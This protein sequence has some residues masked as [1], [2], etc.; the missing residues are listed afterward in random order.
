MTTEIRII[1]PGS[2][3]FH[4]FE[5]AAANLYPA[6]ILP[7]QLMKGMNRDFLHTFYVAVKNNKVTGR[8]GLYHNPQLT[9]QHQ[10]A[11][12]A[13][14]YE[15]MNDTE[16]AN[17]LL[18]Q[19]VKDA[20]KL[21]A[22][23]LIGPMNGSTWDDYRFSTHHQHPNFLLEPYHQLYY[24]DQFV[25][26]GF[27]PIANYISNIDHSLVH[28]H[29][30]VLKTEKE[31]MAKGIVIRSID[32]G[33]YEAE[34]KKLYPFICSSFQTNFLYTQVSEES[35]VSKYK[36]AAAIIDP[37]FVLIAEDQHK[38]IIGFIF[39][40]HDL[41][42]TNP[43]TIVVK[44]VTR[45]PANE[46]KGLGHVMGNRVI[47][48]AAQR[49]FRAAIHAFVIK[50]GTSTGLSNTFSGNSYKNYVLYGMEIQ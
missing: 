12:C 44:T 19:V 20:A 42:N 36:E 38:E 21:G 49:G 6:N 34:L 43:K 2:E 1:E 16:C 5:T 8:A 3:Q 48:A 37:E 28:D 13:G 39:C 40:Y 33:N 9:Y 15:C 17:T 18:Q 27:R 24:N 35:F 45:N 23:F 10:K 30:S 22:K 14:N 32:M 11:V 29:P 41:L 31:L 4:L 25:Q 47:R 50:E 26:F 46:W 7:T